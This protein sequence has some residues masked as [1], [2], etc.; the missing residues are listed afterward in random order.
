[1]NA[2]ETYEHLFV[3]EGRVTLAILRQGGRVTVG[4]S[5]CSP[6]DQFARH[7]GRKIALGRAKAE[8]V[9]GFDFVEVDQTLLHNKQAA[10]Q[11]FIKMAC[12]DQEVLFPGWVYRAV[13]QGEVCT[14]KDLR[15]G[16]RAQALG[17]FFI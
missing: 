11:E 3:G 5:F 12:N 7:R 16:V 4:I 14:V 9:Y 15:A 2:T 10:V 13:K 1:M 8:S 17:E 6:K